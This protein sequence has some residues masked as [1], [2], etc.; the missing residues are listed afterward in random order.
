MTLDALRAQ[1]RPASD[2]DV[3]GAPVL[4]LGGDA[5]V[6][7][8]VAWFGDDRSRRAVHVVT[9][10][11]D[12]GYLLRADVY[13]LMSARWMGSGDAARAILPGTS[14]SWRTLTAE[15]PEPGCPESPVYLVSYNRA[16]PPT[17]RLHPG[18]ALVPR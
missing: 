1:A 18:R 12:L 10:E 2:P 7:A 5:E 9:G 16:R 13:E 14:T 3:A 8:V 15:C 4:R 6:A 17:C 11:E